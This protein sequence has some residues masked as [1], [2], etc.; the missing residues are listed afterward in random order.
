MVR[1]LFFWIS[2]Q[3]CRRPSVN[4]SVFI[5]HILN[6]SCH[7]LGWSILCTWY[8]HWQP[9]RTLSCR[10]SS[11]GCL[12]ILSARLSLPV[13]NCSIWLNSVSPFFKPIVQY[14]INHFIVPLGAWACG[15][16]CSLSAIAH[17]RGNGRGLQ[18]RPDP[19]PILLS[20]TA[21]RLA[22]FFHNNRAGLPHKLVESVGLSSSPEQRTV[23]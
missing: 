21:S 12:D 1:H 22:T 13:S 10:M 2:P 11:I 3:I 9:L 23:S 6:L 5:S 18:E 4:I 17:H 8:I 20:T 19:P 15:W 7:G 16:R 14:K